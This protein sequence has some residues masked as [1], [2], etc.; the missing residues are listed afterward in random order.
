MVPVAVGTRC[1]DAVATLAAAIEQHPPWN[2]VVSIVVLGALVC[3][4]RSGGATNRAP[5]GDNGGRERPPSHR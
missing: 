2:V 4:F 3:V 5:D 1:V